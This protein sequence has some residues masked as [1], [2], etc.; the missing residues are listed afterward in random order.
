MFAVAADLAEY[1][2][3]DA[4]DTVD[5]DRV[6]A[7]LGY[8]SGEI[9]REARQQIGAV[10]GDQIE[11]S[12]SWDRSIRLPQRPVTAVTAVAV[13]D[14]AG[15]AEA[16]TA[17][18]DYRWRRNG[19]LLR[20]TAFPAQRVNTRP[21]GRHWGGDHATVQVTYDHGYAT[22]PADI[23]GLAIAVAARAFDNPTAVVQESFGTYSVTNARQAGVRLTESDRRSLRKWVR[24]S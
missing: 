20:L 23:A 13:I 2:G 6:T 21:S 12:G 19:Q 4:F 1:L 14:E 7:L 9:Q 24:R 5:S 22:I 18:V 11:I 15:V 16:L 8:A 17:D 10:A 3:V